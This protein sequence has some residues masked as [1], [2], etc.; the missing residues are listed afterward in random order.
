MHNRRTGR[1]LVSTE[2]SCISLFTGAGGLDYGF[3]AAGFNTSIAVEMDPWCCKTLRANRQWPIIEGRIEDITTGQIL[4]TGGLRKGEPDILIGGPPCQPFSKAGYWFTGDVKRLE[5]PRAQTLNEYIRVLGEA[6][7]KA[8]LI[9][10][11]YGLAYEGKNEGLLYLKKA[12]DAINKLQGVNYTF[13][14]AVLNSADFG[15]P[16]IRERVF[17]VGSRDGIPFRFPSP[18]FI[19]RVNSRTPG[20]SIGLFQDLETY[21]NTW[22]AIGDLA[23]PVAKGVPKS[24]IGGKWAELLPSIPPGENYLY[25]TNKGKGAPIFKWR[26]RYWSFLLKLHPELPS[27]TIQAQPGSSI[28]PFHWENRRLTMREL[29]RIQTF[30]DDVN[31]LGG[32]TQVQKQ[33]GNAVP[34]AMAEVLAKEI[35]IQFFRDSLD[36]IDIQLVPKRRAEIPRVLWEKDVPNK[37]LPDN[38]D[39]SM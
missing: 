10:N 1:A 39:M 7:P 21:R 20:Q 32:I 3:E 23:S 6:L 16:Q 17:I 9:E 11:V 33:I 12:V 19:S 18:R 28:G 35:R 27:W 29:A 5:D 37:Y 30:P 36:S 25:H 24:Q 22:D 34:S 2:R 31:V 14:W 38:D 13:N 4:A 8:F 15:V 26:S